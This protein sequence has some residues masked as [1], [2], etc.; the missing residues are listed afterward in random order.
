MPDG[1]YKANSE[2]M[3]TAQTALERAAEKT[4]GKADKVAPTPLTA[5]DFGRVHGDAFTGYQK[6]IEAI[7]AAMKGYAGQ[8]TQLGGGVGTAATRYSS[9]DEQ[10]ANAA[11]KAGN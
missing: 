1:G 3:L 11:K 9:A 10:Q 8:L 4:S 2:A 6:G 5:K 7:G